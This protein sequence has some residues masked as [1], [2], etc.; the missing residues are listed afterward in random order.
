MY[1][2]LN[3]SECSCQTEIGQPGLTATRPVSHPEDMAAGSS[4]WYVLQE[5]SCRNHV[6]SW[7]KLLP[8]SPQIQWSEIQAALLGTVREH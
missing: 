1:S 7:Y 4:L 5:D 2:L 6:C 3:V 8:R